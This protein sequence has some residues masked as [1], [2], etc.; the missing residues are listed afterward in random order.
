[1]TAKH[2]PFAGRRPKLTEA[3]VLEL[4]RWG[5][6]GTSVSA[7]AKRFGVNRKTIY[8]YLRGQHKRAFPGEPLRTPEGST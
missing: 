6:Y 1:M 3:Q 5:A 7:V 2:W 4:R 8:Y